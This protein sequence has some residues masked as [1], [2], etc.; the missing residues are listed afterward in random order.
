MKREGRKSNRLLD[1][2]RGMV[3]IKLYDI[4]AMKMHSRK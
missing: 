3:K 4:K 2:I 1:K